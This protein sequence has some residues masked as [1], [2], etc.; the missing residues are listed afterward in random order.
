MMRALWTASTGM[1]AQQLNVD[2]IANNMANVNSVSYKKARVE[3]KDLLYETL[4]RG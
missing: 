4:E 2:T 3:F 1:M